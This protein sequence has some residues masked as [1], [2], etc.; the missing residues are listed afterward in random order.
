MTI[1]LGGSRH[2]FLLPQEIEDHVSKEITANEKFY[3]GDAPGA[4]TA[5]QNFLRKRSYQQVK[6]FS[7]AGYIRNNLGNWDSELVD[8]GLK[9]KSNSTHA[10]K[11]RHMC[12][13]ADS[14]IMIWDGRSAGTLGNVIDLVNQGK[15][16]YMWAV[17][18]SELIQFDNPASLD[19]W[20]LNYPEVRDEAQRRLSTFRKRQARKIKNEAQ[21]GLFK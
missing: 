2:I 21:L 3:V 18:D 17:Q 19:N 6:I 8:T 20:M 12:S 7:S 4:D 16:C 11:D 14:G 1:V 5:F 10:F 9:S 15:S 13:E